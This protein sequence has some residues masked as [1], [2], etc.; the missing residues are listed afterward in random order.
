MDSIAPSHPRTLDDIVAGRRAWTR[1]T[2]SPA[3]WTVRLTPECLTELRAVLAEQ[4][5]SPLP[6]FLLSPADFELHAC[7]ALMDRV[8]EVLRDGVMFAVVDRLPLEE[9]T[10]DE[11]TSVYWLLSSLLARP[12][13]QKL[14][15]QMLFD[16]RDTGAKLKPG[17]GIR[18]T[19]TNVDLTF[20]NDNSYNETPPEVVALLC[21]QTALEGG[22]SRVM[23]VYTAHNA[24]LAEH[25]AILPRLY[26][27]FWYDRHAEHEPGDETVFAAPVFEYGD[28]L[29]ARLAVSEIKAGYALHGQGMD[30]ET[31]A[32]LEAVQSVFA[33]PE[34]RAELDF[35]PGQIQYVNNRGTGHARTDFVDGAAPEKKRHLVRLWLRDAGRRGYRG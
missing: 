18:P 6:L 21:L 12:V 34:L 5:R 30:E 3:D 19:V 31:A 27:P 24:L 33:R 29:H 22:V 1:D 32:A 15:G 14:N 9:M 26:R 20:H 7:R 8:R 4:R 2:I 25:R 11:A 16:V 23:S 10:R 35:H 13:A 17:S 28:R